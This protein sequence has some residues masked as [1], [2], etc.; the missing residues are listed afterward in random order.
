MPPTLREQV[1]ALS[2]DEKRQLVAELCEELDEWPKP[3]ALPD[4][5]LDELARREANL[6]ANPGSAITWDEL[7]RRVKAKT[8]HAG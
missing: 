6:A 8:G 1:A 5:L 3:A 4:S 7:V 2:R